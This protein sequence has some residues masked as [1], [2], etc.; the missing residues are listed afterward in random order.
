MGGE[1]ALGHRPGD[2]AARHT[3]PIWRLF[4]RLWL[5]P[6]GRGLP[7]PAGYSSMPWPRSEPRLELAFQFAA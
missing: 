5:V 3:P 4:G 1:G 6:G 7:G 2:G